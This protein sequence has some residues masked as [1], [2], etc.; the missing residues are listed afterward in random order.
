MTTVPPHGAKVVIVTGASHG[1]GAGVAMCFRRAGYAVVVNSRSIA[2]T[3]DHDL[4][5]VQG[6]ISE[7]ATAQLVVDEALDRFGRI[8]TLINNAGLY[9][10]KRF[11]EYTPGDFAAMLSVNLAGFFHITQ[12][13]IRQFVVQRRG[14]VVNITTSLVDHARSSTPSALTSLTKGGVDGVTRSLAIEYAA[15]GIRV[16]AVARESSRH[17]SA[18]PRPTDPWR[19]A[20]RSAASLRSRT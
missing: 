12:R 20:T 1:I 13:V 17:L 19:T 18:T 9:M 8:D 10:S 6:D 16:N 4:L 14:H 7:P 3:D 11:T 5:A 2:Q 15:A